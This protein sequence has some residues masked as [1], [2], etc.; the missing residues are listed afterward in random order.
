MYRKLLLP[1]IG[2]LMLLFAI[3]HVV[4]A[5]QTP[6]H[7][8]PLTEPATSPFSAAIAG[9]GVVEPDT[10]NIAV[11]SHLPGVVERVLVK[12]GDRVEKGKTILFQLD[13][14]ALRAEWEARNA[15]L[16]A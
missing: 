10:E 5:N 14:R 3:Y 11:G 9:T 2:A 12:V 6:G 16:A 13:D 4:R 8:T 1:I 7:T 15:N